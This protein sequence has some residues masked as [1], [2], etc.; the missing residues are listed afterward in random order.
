MLDLNLSIVHDENA[1]I[2]AV[3][4]SCGIHLYFRCIS[5]ARAYD[6]AALKFRGFDADINFNLSD[7][8]EDMKQVMEVQS[9]HIFI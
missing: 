6:R 7:Y 8:E 4:L 1:I 5:C 2:M 3:F 9:N